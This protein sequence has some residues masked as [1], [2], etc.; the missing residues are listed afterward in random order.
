[1]KYTYD[2]LLWLLLYG[3]MKKYVFKN[4]GVLILKPIQITVSWI[5][6][7]LYLKIPNNGKKA[8]LKLTRSFINKK[9]RYSRLSISLIHIQ[10]RRR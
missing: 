6:E 3:S 8:E 10:F 2:V 9:S 5:I 4:K 7:T 1:M